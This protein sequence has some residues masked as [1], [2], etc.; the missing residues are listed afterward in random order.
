MGNS[1][2]RISLYV[3]LT[4]GALFMLFPFIWTLI[5]SGVPVRA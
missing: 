4:V 2:G 3:I 5:T 1:F